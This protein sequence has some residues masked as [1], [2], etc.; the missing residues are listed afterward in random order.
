MAWWNRKKSTDRSR[1]SSPHVQYGAFSD[2]GRIRNENE[3]AYGCFPDEAG[4]DQLFVVADGM[5]GHVRGREASTTAVDAIQ[6]TYFDAPERAVEARLAEAFERSNAQVHTLAESNEM[7]EKMGTTGTAL[8]LNGDRAVIAHVGDSRAYR[9]SEDGCD[10]LTSD[11]TMVAQMRREGLL[12]DQEARNH[13]RRGTLTRA[14]GADPSVSVDVL[15]VDGLRPGDRF[16]L[17]TDGLAEIPEDE[18]CHVVLA[19]D[20]QEACE[21]LV[22]RANE[23]GG[24]DNATAIVVAIAASAA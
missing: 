15:E 4:R 12:T 22:R 6:R 9:I 17:C 16:L 21:E 7:G 24:Y 11:H 18:L 5:G 1:A 10:L 3:D 20:S 14:I 8:A 2:V 13:P 23:K 19:H